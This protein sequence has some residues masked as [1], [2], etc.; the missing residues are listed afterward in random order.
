MTTSKAKTG[1]I[2]QVELLASALN[3]VNN[4]ISAIEAEIEELEKSGISNASP[5]WKQGKYLYLVYKTD[6]DGNR[7]RQY[8]GSE[9]AAVE[10]ALARIERFSKWI[11]LRTKLNEIRSRERSARQSIDHALWNLNA[12]QRNFWGE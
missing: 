2:D 7:Q 11:D 4:K 10:E 3:E 9:P 1:Q 12:I 8:I 5:W 6:D